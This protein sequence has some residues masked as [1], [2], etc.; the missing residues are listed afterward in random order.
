MTQIAKTRRAVTL[1]HYLTFF[2]ILI[3]P[4][5]LIVYLE[6]DQFGLSA[7]D[8]PY[9]LLA[10]LCVCELSDAFDGHFARK[11]NQVSDFGKLID[12]MADSISRLSV[13]LTF[14]QP[15]VKVP[16]ILVFLFLYRDCIISTL[17]TICALRGVTLAA[18]T[19]GKIKAV[20]QAIA[21]FLIV[22]MMIPH[23]HGLITT[24]TLHDVSTVAVACAA[25]YSLFSAGEYIVANRRHIV[26][27]LSL[28]QT[29][30][31]L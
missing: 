7:N 24:Q 11:Y 15:P 21:A 12:P 19:S 3:S 1:A 6:Y 4:L 17:R 25:A 31:P 27:S 5:F 18:R 13:F 8:L 23:S 29:Q 2:R 16:M 9:V 14:T 28:R 20:I 22:L 26:R 30:T 10:L